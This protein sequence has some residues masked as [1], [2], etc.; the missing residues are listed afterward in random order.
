MNSLRTPEERFVA[1]PDF[2]FSP[3]YVE[4]A[5]GDGGNLRV[6]Y[7]DEG[8]ADGPVVL[9]LHGEPSWSYLYRYMIPVLN[10]HGLR[11]IAPDLVG[12]GRSDKPTQ[13]SDYTY[14]NHVN[15]L[16]A[17]IVA[18]KLSSI[19][20]VCQDWGGLLGLR[21]VGENPELF[22]RVIA[23]NTSFPTGDKPASAAFLAW[24]K[25]SQESQEFP[26]GQIIDTGCSS[27][28]TPEVIAAY[29]APFP[30][31]S[32]KEGARKFPTLVPTSPD[33]PASADNRK[34]WEAL[35]K[36][37]RP[38]LCTFSD[39]DP[40]TAG[41]EKQFLRDVL[42]CAGQNHTVLTGAGHF[43]QEDCGPEFAEII[44]TFIATT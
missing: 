5:D 8:P 24:Q 17:T 16:R 44:A 32:Y 23:A 3:H 18:L 14:Q 30:D 19:N 10:G 31:E 28:L 7:L 1:L 34:A 2:D 37:T 27:D 42:G 26:I 29:N 33:N 39:Q 4:I 38:F 43:L 13:R 22:S 15:W 6:H 41:G 36:F 9:L 35:K 11:T 20:L 21:I 25:F 40:V 12:F